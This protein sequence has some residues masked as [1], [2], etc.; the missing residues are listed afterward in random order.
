MYQKNDLI[1]YGSTG[2]CRVLDVTT[3]AMSGIP[4]GKLYY[5]LEPL[6]QGGVIY[7]PVEN[8]KVSIRPVIT[9]DKAE[10]LI[11]MIPNIRAEAF[12]SQNIQQLT[13]HYQEAIQLQDCESLIEL[14]M[15]IY[16]KKQNAK[17]LKRKFGQV[18]AK[19]MKRAEELLYGEF[20]V[21]LGIPK[22]SVADYIAE[23]VEGY[24]AAKPQGDSASRS[25]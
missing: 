13:E 11:A 7:A 25:I 14:V 23:R 5:Q 12:V 10:T 2:V 20:A 18:D 16:A 1:V 4:A 15:S 21:A 8:P 6:Y 3:P 24:G 22:D 19:F 9:R 17:L